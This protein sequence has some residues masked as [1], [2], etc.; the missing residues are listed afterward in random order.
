MIGVQVRMADGD[1]V[2]ASAQ[3]STLGAGPVF[4]SR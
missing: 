4:V 2:L 1:A 3:R